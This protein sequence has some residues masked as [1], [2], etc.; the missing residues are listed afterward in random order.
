MTT[1]GRTRAVSELS[2]GDLPIA[3]LFGEQKLYD[4]Y[5]EVVVQRVVHI[6]LNQVVDEPKHYAGLF[7]NL[8]TLTEQDYVIL[9]I[10]CPGGDL[11]TGMQMLNAIKECAATVR[12]ILEGEAYSLGSM[13]LLQCDE[14][15]VLDNTLMM[16]H[17]FGGSIV[18]SGS[19]MVSHLSAMVEWFD[20]FGREIYI[21]FITEEEFERVVEGYQMYISANEIRKRLEQ[22][23]EGVSEEFV[24]E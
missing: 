7:R 3:P 19:E 12:G 21:P 20:E 15:V 13:L 1:T 8:R 18:G 16:I 2:E 9:H 11:T 5:E 23:A 10:N 22:V 4:M 6:D 17:N 14:I 24:S